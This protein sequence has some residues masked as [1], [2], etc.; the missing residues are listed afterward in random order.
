[1]NFESYTERINTLCNIDS[2]RAQKKLVQKRLQVQNN[3]MKMT[4]VNKVQ[5]ASLND[6]RYYFSDEIVSLPFGH[7][8]L[9]ELRELKKSYLK[10]HTV[11][12]KEKDILL[13][14]EN[15]AVARDL[16][17]YGAFTCSQ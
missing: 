15:Q 9:S 11:I 16:E 6:K 2:E 4:S 5:F 10:I 13:K 8:L 14:L 3:E 7:P 1:M 12:E 17:F